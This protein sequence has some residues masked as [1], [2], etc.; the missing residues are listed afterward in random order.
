MGFVWFHAMTPFGIVVQ[1]LLAYTTKLE[2]KKH[3]I[4]A[5]IFLPSKN[6]PMHGA[7]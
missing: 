1:K 3:T 2:K 6:S 7:F 4:H 5:P